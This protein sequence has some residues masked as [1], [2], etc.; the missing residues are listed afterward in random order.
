MH[1]PEIKVYLIS[2]F[3]SKRENCKNLVHTK[4]ACFTVVDVLL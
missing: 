3:Y 4:N 2:R 1:I